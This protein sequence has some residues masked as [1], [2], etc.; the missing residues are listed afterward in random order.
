VVTVVLPVTRYAR[1]PDGFS[2]AY[3]TFGE[4]PV[5][6]VFLRKWEA[7][8]EHD[9]EDGVLGHIFERIGGFGR[10]ILFDRRG[11]GLSDPIGDALPTLDVRMDDLTA[12]LDASGSTVVNL[13]SVGVA[14]ASFCCFYAATHPAR[15]S[16]FVLYNGQ[17]CGHQAPGYPWGPTP[18]A[19]ADGRAEILEGWGNAQYVASTMPSEASSRAGDKVWTEWWATSER[20]SASPRVALALYEMEVATDVRPVLP[21]I[22]SRTLVIRRGPVKLVEEAE[23]IAAQIPR[24]ELLDMPGPDHML[25]SGDTDAVLDEIERFITGSVQTAPVLDR[26][27]TTILFTDVGASTEQL[28]V[29]GDHA[30][31]TLIQRHHATVRALLDTYRGKELDTAGDGFFA[32]FDGPARAVRCAQEIVAAVSQ[33]GLEVRAGVHTGECEY[34]DGKVAGLAVVVAARVMGKA[35]PGT[36]LVTGTVKDLTAGSGIDLADVG[37]HEL[38]GIPGKWALFAAVR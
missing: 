5:D 29:L 11:T 16:N 24:A 3:Q 22:A 2:I 18:E 26:V 33:I 10:L 32:V 8:V 12:V 30:W 27:L 17:V 35:D 21:S 19:I 6:V 15:V 28:A 14:A 9:W 7:N 34:L 1:T 37:T 4:G 31:S 25:L 13:V 36:V 20:R 38:K 23:W